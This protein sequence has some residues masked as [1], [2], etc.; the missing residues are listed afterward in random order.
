MRFMGA[1]NNNNMVLEATVIIVDN[2][3]YA[4]NG[5]ILPSRFD[6]QTEAVNR[7]ATA[8][9]DENQESAVGL[10]TMGGHNSEVLLTPVKEKSVIMAA[11]S[12][13]EVWGD[14]NLARAIMVASLSLKH[15]ANKNQRQRII[16]MVSSPLKENLKELEAMG[17]KLSKNQIALDV[18]NLGIS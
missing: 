15:R 16:A 1:T 5:D 7:L 14:S 3:K 13:V 18:I 8:K 10:M 11:L 2:S 9:L 6:A 12:K 17:K 4:V